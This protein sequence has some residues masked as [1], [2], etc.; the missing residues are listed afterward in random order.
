MSRRSRRQGRSAFSQDLLPFLS[1]MLGLMSV[2]ALTTMAIT[3][4][5][6]REM[7]Q[8][9]VVKLVAIPDRFEPLQIRCLR[10][11]IQWQDDSGAWRDMN[12]S[13][14]SILAENDDRLLAVFPVARLFITW[15]NDKVRANAAL[16]Y[17]RKQHTLIL[18]I[19]P[20]GVITSMMFEAMVDTRGL[21][22]RI[23]KLPATEGDQ[24]LAP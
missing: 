4:S 14:L 1:I 7:Q 20:D 6:R 9:T 15:L 12:N 13:N 18:W 19:E 16:S 8:T 24:I 11:G 5:K 23:G 22:I 10:D 2:M 3:V 21:P 17:E